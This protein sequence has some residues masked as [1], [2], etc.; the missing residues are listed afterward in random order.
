[1]LFAVPF[2][3]LTG[4]ALVKMESVEEQDIFNIAVGMTV[5][6]IF[7]LIIFDDQEIK[8]DS[9]GK[10]EPARVENMLI[11]RIFKGKDDKTKED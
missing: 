10:L 5:I 4:Y 2:S 11:N 6:N 7:L 8:V 3:S 9:D 1:M